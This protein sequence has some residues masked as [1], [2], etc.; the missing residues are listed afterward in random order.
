MDVTY[1]CSTDEFRQWLRDNHTTEQEILVGFYKV[2]TGKPSMTWSNSV[3]VALCFGWIDSVRRTVDNESYCIRFTPRKPN[4]VWSNINIEKVENL[5]KA[6]LMTEA[7]LEAYSKRKNEKSGIYSFENDNRTLPDHLFNILAENLNAFRFFEQLAPSYK[8]AHIH[9]I[10]S[11]KQESTRLTRLY[12]MIAA[13]EKNE[14]L[15]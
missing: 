3:D 15:F 11:A 6:G 12:K 14:R 13:F 8:K 7:G 4:S 1:F 2:S 5:T 10:V 9:W